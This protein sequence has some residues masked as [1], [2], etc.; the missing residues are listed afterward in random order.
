[1]ECVLIGLETV[2][3][4]STLPRLCTARQTATTFH[5]RQARHQTNPATA[6]RVSSSVPFLGMSGCDPHIQ[7]ET[8]APT[9]SVRVRGLWLALI[10]S[11][12]FHIAAGYFATTV[13]M[14]A[15]N[16]HAA[17]MRLA[18]SGPTMLLNFDPPPDES[19]TT[20]K[21]PELANKTPPPDPVPQ[22]KPEPPDTQLKL[23]IS[24]SNQKSPNWLGFADP[25][26][27]SARKS[28]VE[29][30]AL[31]PNAGKLGEPAPPPVPTPPAPESPMPPMAE[32]TPP[33]PVAEPQPEQ[34]PA[35]PTLVTPTQ[36]A[37]AESIP[38][39]PLDV[40]PETAPPAPTPPAPVIPTPPP[41]ASP[42]M[43]PPAPTEQETA[44]PA[45]PSKDEAP[46]TPGEAMQEM[47]ALSPRLGDPEAPPAPE[48]PA[49]FVG[50]LPIE[51]LAML[52]AQNPRTQ[53][54]TTGIPESIADLTRVAQNSAAPKPAQPQSN[55]AR[56]TPPQPSGTPPSGAA[57]ARPP[58]PPQVPT[59]SP[60]TGQGAD[61][62][63]EQSEKQSDAT[64]LTTPI[65]IR[66]GRP[67]A[68]Q[69]LDIVTQRPN[70]TRLTRVISWPGNPLLKVTFNRSGLVINVELVESSGVSDIDDPVI[71]AIYRW[72]AR[73][74]TLDKLPSEN[75]TLTVSVRI[76][77]R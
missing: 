28:E 53:G 74:K 14:E 54:E 37:A 45:T 68:S 5:N 76:L 24:D 67:A 62:D 16:A 51:L 10:F 77:L 35:P 66:L 39:P 57:G 3:L 29:Q 22:P 46:T 31:D 58:N 33:M 61:R 52:D 2:A 64:S 26:E 75:S 17:A 49:N 38:A 27:H 44:E 70:F 25:T 60:P 59:V 48:L 1:M 23:G 71:N 15:D 13:K 9:S 41:E 11:V 65:E 40:P 47:E 34:P 20:P 8:T 18:S 50:P 7:A 43:T 21:P 55:P 19:A 32:P 36:P 56:P 6:P 72:T 63:A 30:P 73:G 12:I 42:A 69:G 4:G